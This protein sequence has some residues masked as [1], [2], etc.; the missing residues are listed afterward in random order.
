MIRNVTLARRRLIVVIAVLGLIDLA[1][2]V[3]LFSPAVGSGRSGRVQYEGLNQELA[4]KRLQT[5]PALDMDKKLTEAR[6][7]I[8]DFY[9]NH[10]ADRYSEIAQAVAKAAEAS[11]V[12]VANVRY[13]TKQGEGKTA[14]GKVISD[15]A[16]AH[17][18][19]QVNLSMEVGG[20]YENEIR[21][22][23]A[24]ER[25]KL[26]MVIE[27]VNLAEAQG[28]ILRLGIRVQTFLRMAES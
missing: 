2:L 4:Q 19:V 1:V 9:G 17:G 8:T 7:Q 22:L 24:L 20:S 3:F 26:L 28:G 14:E 12:Q 13:E 5:L 27:S 11:H 18:L 16:T 15:S 25:S 10:L 23:N 6:G 21:F